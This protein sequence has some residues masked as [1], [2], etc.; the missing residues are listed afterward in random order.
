MGLY[1]YMK[2][3]ELAHSLPHED[4]MRGRLSTSPEEHPHQNP[5]ML[6]SLSWA[7]SLRNGETYISVPAC[8][9]LSR[10]PEQTNTVRLRANFH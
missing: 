8:G 4:T 10:P 2:R 9:I 5:T 7:S 1:P 3:P 6:A